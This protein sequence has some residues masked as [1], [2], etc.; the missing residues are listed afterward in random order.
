LPQRSRVRLRAF[1]RRSERNGSFAV[2]TRERV[3]LRALLVRL[4][5][6]HCNAAKRAMPKRRPRVS[7]H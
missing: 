7:G 2:E 3:E 1:R 6:Q 4:A 5:A